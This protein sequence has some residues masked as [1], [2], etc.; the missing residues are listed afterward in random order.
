M[1]IDKT[2]REGDDVTVDRAVKIRDYI[3]QLILLVGEIA[4]VNW[5]EIGCENTPFHK[6]GNREGFQATANSAIARENEK[7][8]VIGLTNKQERLPVI[9]RLIITMPDSAI[10][11]RNYPIFRTWCTFGVF[12]ARAKLFSL[13]GNGCSSAATAVTIV[14]QVA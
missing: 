14:S 12:P 7:Y 9:I 10:A 13:S 11:V 5:R 1:P 3:E 4:R 8:I 6:N 2:I